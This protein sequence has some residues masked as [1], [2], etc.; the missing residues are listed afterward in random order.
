MDSPPGTDSM[1]W[2]DSEPKEWI[3]LL[4]ISVVS[5]NNV[6]NVYNLHFKTGSYLKL[7]LIQKKI[8]EMGRSVT[9]LNVRNKNVLWF[10]SPYKQRNTPVFLIQSKIS[11]L[12]L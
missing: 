3:S 8:H 7:L 9:H 12:I 1:Q 6:F 2:R 11:P 4:S 5:P 10:R